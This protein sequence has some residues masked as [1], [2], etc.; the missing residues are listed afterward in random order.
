MTAADG[1]PGLPVPLDAEVALLLQTVWDMLAAGEHWPTYQRV[2]RVL[3]HQHNLAVDTIISRTSTDLLW[4]GR[5]EGGAPPR[6]DGQLTLTLAG[7]ASCSGSGPAIDVVVAAAH[8]AADAERDA[9]PADEDP[10]LTYDE[11]ARVVGLN[12]VGARDVAR[13]SGLLLAH[14]PW[15]GGISLSHESWQ[16]PVDRR[17]RPYAGVHDFADYWAR[18]QAEEGLANGD[19]KAVTAANVIHLNHRW[20]L[21]DPLNEGSF[22]QVIA[23]TG[24]DGSSVA[25]KLVPK[26]P[27]ADRELLFANPEGVRN[28]VPF[29]DFGETADAY[30][31]VM[32]R[33]DTTL[34]Q[35]LFDA[36]GALAIEEALAVLTD[37][38]TALADLAG[39]VVHR[40][41]KPENIMLLNGK[42]CLA[43]FGI[44]RYA[45]AST[46]PDTRKYSMTG[47]YAAPEQWRLERATSAADVYAVGVIAFELLSG[48]RP[49]PGPDFYDFREQHLHQLPPR[50]EGVNPQL[51]AVVQDCL[52]KPQQARPTPSSL[53]ERLQRAATPRLAPGASALADAYRDQSERRAA[54]EA[55]ASRAM[56][57]QERRRALNEA[58][59]RTLEG[60]SNSVRSIVTEVAPDIP[61]RPRPAGGWEIELGGARLVVSAAQ[62]RD[63]DSNFPFDVIASAVVSVAV[64]PN[65]TGWEGRSHSL[66][67]CDAQRA[68][69]YAWFET[70]FMVISGVRSREPFALPPEGEAAGALSP[71]M[72]TTQVAWPF[73]VVVP[74]EVDEFAD[75]WIGWF[76]AAVKGE[77]FR[78]STLPERNPAGSWRRT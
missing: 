33:A 41:I 20:V 67:Y 18:R 55:A 3:Y 11:A 25:V 45:E 74:G 78:P 59:D 51:G 29:L 7:A 2:D 26:E 72:T 49:F 36:G 10:V 12:L 35:R 53:L 1:V 39:R 44:S 71:V 58:A 46:A 15:T 23:G 37:V 6:D 8:L 43:D 57:E 69:E 54:A 13:Q 27:G 31:M 76:G 73:T 19:S 61:V 21:G 42:W 52:A 17:A 48:Q 47:A 56:T 4:G 28:V 70:A 40:D 22:G 24:D 14:E 9:D 34:R 66:W 75:R 65:R 62:E 60:I 5:P 38:V 50:L 30:V 63:T 64:P 32:P 77:L 16:I 68:G